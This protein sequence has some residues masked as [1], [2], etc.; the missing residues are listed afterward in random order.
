MSSSSSISAGG[1]KSMLRQHT[2]RIAVQQ[3]HLYHSKI[4]LAFR[5]G[6]A[7]G[8]LIGVLQH[9]CI[10]LGSNPGQLTYDFAVLGRPDH[11]VLEE[12][13]QLLASGNIA[14]TMARANWSVS[15]VQGQDF[16]V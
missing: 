12:G 10:A 1:I 4:T 7:R 15:V 16:L 6:H 3:F 9:R 2:R 14:A 5:G 13:I 8:D 11:F